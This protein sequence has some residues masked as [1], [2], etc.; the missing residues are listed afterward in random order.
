MKVSYSKNPREVDLKIDAE[1]ANF[2]IRGDIFFYDIKE[3]FNDKAFEKYVSNSLKDFKD[4]SLFEDIEDNPNNIF[5]PKYS[6]KTYYK[7]PFHVI[8]NLYFLNK[9][10]SF[11]LKNKFTGIFIFSQLIFND[12]LDV[13]KFREKNELYDY[14]DNPMY[15]L[16]K[17][18]SMLIGD[19]NVPQDE[20]MKYLL[21]LNNSKIINY[22]D[23]PHSI[24]FCSDS[25]LGYMKDIEKVDYMSYSCN[26]FEYKHRDEMESVNI[27]HVCNFFSLIPKYLKMGGFVKITFTHIYKISSIKCF[28]LILNMFNDFHIHEEK[29]KNYIDVY[30]IGYKDNFDPDV[31]KVL[32][33]II[34]SYNGKCGLKQV[35]Y[36]DDISLGRTANYVKFEDYIVKKTEKHVLDKQ[37]GLSTILFYYMLISNNYTEEEVRK[38]HIKKYIDKY[39]NIKKY[40]ITEGLQIEN[41]VIMPEDVIKYLINK[42]KR[43]II[44]KENISYPKFE[45]IGFIS[46]K[47]SRRDL[48]LDYY[49]TYDIIKLFFG[50]I[51]VKIYK[52]KRQIDHIFDDKYK[53]NTHKFKLF[54]NLKYKFDRSYSQAFLKCLEIIDHIPLPRNICSFHCCESPG[55]FVLAF[56][57]V[58]KK[59]QIDYNWTA[60]SLNPKNKNNINSLP[61]DYGL[62]KKYKDN[63]DFGKDDSGDILNISNVK[64]YISNRKKYNMYTSDCGMVPKYLGDQESQY[65]KLHFFQILL[66]II[67][68]E[69]GGNMFVKLFL[70]FSKKINLFLISELFHNFEKIQYIK[71]KVN[72][73][74]SEFYVLC[75]N[76]TADLPKK[77]LLE[78]YLTDFDS[79]FKDFE[80]SN[81]SIQSD[82]VTYHY[83]NIEKISKSF[84]KAIIRNLFL[85]DSVDNELRDFEKYN[86]ELENKWMAKYN[87][88]N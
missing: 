34:K 32:T 22:L 69:P 45:D 78:S 12:I 46:E 30:F 27:I 39:K 87:N 18:N 82:I 13:K 62:I 59:K 31:L 21:E 28:Y 71:P 55:N 65:L 43:K 88:L 15:T 9:H 19:N 3:L 1:K 25:F 57:Y 85:K 54:K 23:I 41:I 14:I 81:F 56:S 40:L 44:W 66:G 68:L 76:S 77:K 75:L 52:I 80:S 6:F 47:K 64:H 35:K 11:F 86:K 29:E 61:D 8:R 16:I 79:F 50:K 2:N 74:S 49:I 51:N 67:L 83:Y 26:I 58:C 48:G 70:P 10:K 53:I 63:W 33:K 84:N 5:R 60:Q 20:V 4:M 37:K 72:T 38:L 24:N 36:I 17:L 73:M 42:E 7:F